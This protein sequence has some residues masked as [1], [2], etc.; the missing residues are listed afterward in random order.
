MWALAWGICVGIVF[1]A[2]SAAAVAWGVVWASGGNAAG[3]IAGGTLGLIMGIWATGQCLDESLVAHRRVRHALRFDPDEGW[4]IKRRL[5]R[6]RWI[7]P[8]TR[9]GVDGRRRDGERHFVQWLT[10][11]DVIGRQRRFGPYHR[12][13]KESKVNAMLKWMNRHIADIERVYSSG[14]NPP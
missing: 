8:N 6:A 2:G 13:P 12:R 3:L 4:V 10:V 1:I 9:A 7:G 14:T 11:T 5:R